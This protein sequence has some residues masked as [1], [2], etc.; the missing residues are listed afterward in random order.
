L[1][2]IDKPKRPKTKERHMKS[3]F[4]RIALL[5]LASAIAIASADTT[6]G[7]VEW[8]WTNVKGNGAFAFKLI[9]STGKDGA[10]NAI[11]ASNAYT[12]G[13]N[14]ATTPISMSQVLTAKAANFNLCVD[15][16]AGNPGSVNSIN[17]MMP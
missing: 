17:V 14:A 5:S 9:N 7:K 13:Y 1:R 3:I 8:A 10:G 16:P 4:N 12:I 11:P 6:C 15:F 2:L